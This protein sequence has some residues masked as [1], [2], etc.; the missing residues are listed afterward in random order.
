MN[1]SGCFSDGSVPEIKKKKKKV[2]LSD[3]QYGSIPSPE[4]TRHNTQY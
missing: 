4:D 1:Q 3:P 2:T